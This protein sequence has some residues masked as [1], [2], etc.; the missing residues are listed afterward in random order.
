MVHR[1]PGLGGGPDRR[2][3]LHGDHYGH[4]AHRRAGGTRGPTPRPGLRRAR[5]PD[6]RPARQDRSGFLSE[7]SYQFVIMP[8]SLGGASAGREA[9]GDPMLVLTEAAAEVV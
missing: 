8:A 6:V 4:R 2:A 9:K 1:P 3:D 7:S 5:R